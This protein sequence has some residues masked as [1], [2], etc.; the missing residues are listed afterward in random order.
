MG[1]IYIDVDV[2]DSQTGSRVS[3]A[4]VT[5]AGRTYLSDGSNFVKAWFSNTLSGT[6]VPLLVTCSGYKTYTQNITLPQFTGTT[7]AVSLQATGGAQVPIQVVDDTT[8]QGIASAL[9]FV[10]ADPAKTTDATGNLLLTLSSG[11]HNVRAVRG[12]VYGEGATS[13]TVTSGLAP[14][15]VTLALTKL[16][17][18]QFQLVLSFE[19]TVGNPA[20]TQGA[21]ITVGTE[22]LSADENGQV[23]TSLSYN[24]GDAVAVGATKDGWDNFS[25]S[26]TVKDSGPY[27]FQLQKST[28]D[29][30]PVNDAT[31]T[32]V[33]NVTPVDASGLSGGDL[34]LPGKTPDGYEYT[35]PSNEFGKYFTVHQARMYIGNLFVDELNTVQYMLQANRI[36]V[37][38]YASRDFDAMGSGKALVQGQLMINFI[39]EGY[40][41]TLLRESYKKHAAATQDPNKQDTDQWAALNDRK[42]AIIAELQNG[43][44]QVYAPIDSD[45][46]SGP[47]FVRLPT[48]R[49]RT[50]EQI[51]AELDQVNQKLQEIARRQGPNL[52]TVDDG[53]RQLTS[54]TVPDGYNNAVY[55]PLP[56]DIEIVLEG[57]GRKVKRKLEQCYLIS[58]EQLMDMSGDP[59]R[60]I[61]GFVARRLR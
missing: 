36:P 34:P 59:I 12:P 51:Q 19:P 57:A 60:E 22:T 6:S 17:V 48:D 33:S 23:R 5:L 24:V 55:L 9:V 42:T 47:G 45:P 4:R 37:Y 3:G 31:L 30:D 61:Y 2:V 35:Y 39:S 56:F 38:G 29:S 16:K 40:L 20:P 44:T 28:T 53:R 1:S 52:K 21:I 32:P 26:V 49:T 11:V 8:R 13:I 14:G 41:Y 50:G 46:G 7:Q 10:D 54:F 18:Q 58:N 27:T 15:Q 25:T 43:P